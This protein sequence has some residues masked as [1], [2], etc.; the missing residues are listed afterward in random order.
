MR[1]AKFY[2]REVLVN[3]VYGIVN[4]DKFTRN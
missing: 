4:C 1:I 2:S 3:E